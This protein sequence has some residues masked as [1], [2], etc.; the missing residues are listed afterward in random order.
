[1]AVA[2][3]RVHGSD[4]FLTGFVVEKSLSVDNLF[5]FMLILAASLCPVEVRQRVLLFG[6][7]GAIALRGV[8]IGL[9]AAMLQ[10][11]TW[12]FLVFG[13]ILLVSAAKLLHEA[14]SDSDDEQQ[15]VREMR[16]VRVFAPSSPGHGKL[17]R[18]QDLDS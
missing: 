2:H 9:G 8:F 3:V 14:L 7:V 1:M 6:I 15:N 16:S 17:S 11:G 10:A 12:A 13:G 5:V 4:D 18:H